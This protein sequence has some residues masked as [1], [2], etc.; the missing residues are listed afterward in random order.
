MASRL[1]RT[2]IREILKLTRMPGTISF[3]GGLP[4]PAIFPYQAVEEATLKALREKGRLALQYS[5]TE[6]EPFFKE[7]IARFQER[8]GERVAPEEMIIVSSSQQGL[9]LLAK[10]FIDAGSPIIIERPCYAGTLQAFSSFG[11]D[12]HGVDMDDEGIIPDRLERTIFELVKAGRKPRFVYLIPDFQNP[13][14][15]NLSL[16]RRR[17]ILR[18]AAE[19]DLLII[20][21]SPYRELRFTG[22]LI[23]SIRSLD[24]EGRV[25][26]MKTFSKVFC[27]GFRI[28]WVVAP[29]AILEKL[30][31]SKQGT[32]LCTSAFVSII[33]GYLLKDGHVENQIDIAKRLY[34]KKARVMLEALQQNLGDLEGVSWSKPEGGMFL[35]LRL[36]EYMDTVEMIKDAV[37]LK[38]AY[39]VGTGFY[40]DGS[41][42]HEMRLNFSY[43]TEEQI[44]TGIE[45]LSRL[46]KRRARTTL[47]AR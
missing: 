10:V 4:D 38:V 30:V 44:M 42:H 12:F 21:D 11:A 31:M 19:Y 47:I 34:A 45:R 9:D 2:E 43:P 41:G 8:Q 1:R 26:Q 17:Q 5:P 7:E 16:E 39:V 28:G 35:W 29:P 37:E 23:P 3:G 36:P 46:I 6:G 40:P 32:D 13:S 22:E 33:G 24:R 14:G 18:I 27:P 15:I 25:V 20:E